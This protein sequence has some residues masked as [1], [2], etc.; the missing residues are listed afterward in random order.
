M[1]RDALPSNSEHE[2]SWSNF[3][4]RSRIF[5]IRRAA[6]LL[7]AASFFGNNSEAQMWGASILAAALNLHGFFLK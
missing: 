4:Y 7:G 5:S 1:E 6:G 3:L 2:K